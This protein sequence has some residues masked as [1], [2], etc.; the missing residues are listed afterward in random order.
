MI[1]HLGNGSHLVNEKSIRRLMRPTGLMPIY[2]KP[3]TR[4]A[5]KGRKT[6]PY[7]LKG[8]CVTRQ[9]QI[10]A[11]DIAYLPVRRGFAVSGRHHALAHPQGAG[12]ADI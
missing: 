12:L 7:L 10:W 4:K 8:Q 2:Q 1:W 6:Y 3:D 9:N 11:A 5:A